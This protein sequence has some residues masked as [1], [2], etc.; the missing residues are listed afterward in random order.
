MN[1]STI[2]D[3]LVTIVVAPRERFSYSRESLESIYEHTQYPFNLIYV[4]GNSP[5]HIRDYLAAQA[6]QKQFQLIRQDTYLSP[7]RARNIGLKE[8]KSK[9]V[10][11]ID[12]DVVVSPN[13]LKPLVDCAET[14]QATIVSPLLCQ[15][16][17]IHQEVHCAGGESGV[18]ID[19]DRRRIIEKI[20][21]QGRKVAD[22]LPKLNQQQTGLA[23]FHCML[24]R[25]EIFAQIG[26]LDEALLST[27]EHVD[28]CMLVAKAGG[29]IYLEPA[30]V[31]TYVPG[32]PLELTDIHYYMLRWSD[33]WEL[34]S[35]KHL[36][37]K[38]NLSEDEYFQRKYKRLGS[39][40]QMTIISPFARKL[41]L[42]NFGFRVVNYILRRI[43]K[44]LNRWITSW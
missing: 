18:R 13:W 8:V 43:D 41:S 7:N 42:G 12:N 10:V 11:F 28:L 44:V 19:N 39:R 34:A 22:V 20:Y 33:R 21:D 3:S 36:R 29:T 17:P 32:P 5:A 24:V 37:E 23:E 35:L 4:D 2:A 14:T 26:F 16:T 25:T 15:G 38:W 31:V 1:S 30:S 6:Q 40:R 27:K 9:Y